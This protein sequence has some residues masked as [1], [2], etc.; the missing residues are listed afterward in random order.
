MT[1][2]TPARQHTAAGPVAGVAAVSGAWQIILAHYPP[3]DVPALAALLLAVGLTVTG[4]AIGRYAATRQPDPEL[5][6][7]LRASPSLRLAAVL[8]LASV[9]ILTTVSAG[10]S[11]GLA[12][13]V[14]GPAGV[15]PLIAPA[16][17]PSVVQRRRTQ[18]SRV[19]RHAGMVALAAIALAQTMPE[20][21]PSS[22]NS[23]LI[24][25][26]FGSVI[27][28]GC[29]LIGPGLLQMCRSAMG[30]ADSSASP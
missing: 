21:W 7:L 24:I 19:T 26:T 10:A 11:S 18:A 29:G 6:H 14:I 20:P 3:A 13:A 4:W 25:G 23:A 28:F 16:P 27:A 15:L 9:G 30:A 22:A 8:L 17:P 2:S 12:V 1:D 5:A